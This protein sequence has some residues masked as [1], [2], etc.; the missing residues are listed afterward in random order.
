MTV[1]P[2]RVKLTLSSIVEQFNVTKF[3]ITERLP[4]LPFYAL[5]PLGFV[6]N[7]TIYIFGGQMVQV[8]H[9]QF[10]IWSR[11]NNK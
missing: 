2:F 5:N 7:N 9:Y 8:K 1:L 4:D 10:K 3:E 11:E 6:T